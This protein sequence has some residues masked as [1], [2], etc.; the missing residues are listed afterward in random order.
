MDERLWDLQNSEMEEKDFASLMEIACR[1]HGWIYD[2][3][4]GTVFI[5]TKFESWSFELTK[6]KIKLM[7]KNTRYTAACDYHI[8]WR[9]FVTPKYLVAYINKHGRKKYVGTQT[10][11]TPD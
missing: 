8:Q 6:G 5:H 2:E 7:H 11:I 4:F 9:R 1:Q 3:K 10:S